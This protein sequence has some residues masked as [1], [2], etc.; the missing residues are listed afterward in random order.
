MMCHS[1][2]ENAKRTKQASAVTNHHCVMFCIFRKACYLD[3]CSLMDRRSINQTMPRHIDD[4]DKKCSGR[5]FGRES[6]H[7]SWTGG[8]KIYKIRFLR[9]TSRAFSHLLTLYFLL[10][11]LNATAPSFASTSFASN[12]IFSY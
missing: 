9:L 11:W 4:L 2:N 5:E 7:E 10:C 1:T 8:L 6:E 12:F 3:I